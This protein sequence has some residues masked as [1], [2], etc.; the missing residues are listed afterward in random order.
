MT[1]KQFRPRRRAGS[2]IACCVGLI[3]AQSA[4]GQQTAFDIP[5][6][7]AVRAIPEFARQAGL[8]IVAPADE[9]RGVR[10]AALKGDLDARVALRRLL[11][12]T[13]L[14][15]ASDEG[16]LI[17]LRRTGSFKT[18]ALDAAQAQGSAASTEELQE[19]TVRAV[20][21][22][23][24]EVMSANKMPLSVRDTPQTVKIVTQDLLDFAGVHKFED[25]YKID[26]S[27]GTSHAGDALPR[28]YFRGY[29]VQGVNTI[30]VDGF[31]MPAYVELDLA[32]FERF[33]IVKGATST[34]YG[35]NSVAGSLN[36]ISKMP[37]STF[38]G[39]VSLETGSYQHYRADVDLYGPMNASGTLTYRL[40]GAYLDE[41]E[42]VDFS[43][44]KRKV[45][46]PTIRYELSEDTSIV[47]RFNYQ[48]YDFTPY[49]GVGAQFLGTD[50]E[51]P[52]QL[53]PE[54][55]RIPPIP[56]SETGNSPF[57]EASKKAIIAQTTVDHRFGEGGWMLRGNVQYAHMPGNLQGSLDLGTDADGFTDAEL[58]AWDTDNDVYGA[59]VNLFGDVEWGGRKHTLFFGVDYAKLK[60]DGEYYYTDVFGADDG[61]SI[62]N[63]DYSLRQFPTQRTDYAELF[64]NADRREMSGITM[65]ALLRPLDGLIVSLGARYSHDVLRSR[66]A[67]CEIDATLEGAEADRLAENKITKQLGLTYAL[68][69]SMNLYATYGETFE[70][71]TGLTGP[72]EH[73][74]PE[75]GQA[76]EI[77]AKGD[78]LD[79][80]VSYSLALFNLERN[81]I[82]QD[83][84]GSIYLALAGTQRSRGVELDFQGQVV[85]GWEIYV[86]LAAMDAEF[87]KG[88]L[89]GARPANAPKFGASLFTSYEIQDGPCKGLGFG[90]GVVYKAGR[91]MNDLFSYGGVTRTNFLGDYTE[92][93]LRTFYTRNRWQFE[94]AGT[95]LFNEKYYSNAFAQLQTGYQSNPPRQFMG[96][97]RYKF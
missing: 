46:A 32:P 44:N 41:N 80:R 97:V 86:S 50:I 83:I 96:S 13:G 52:A 2:Q 79:K 28:N 29:Q 26:A 40:I 94:I 62:L 73:A 69:P 7:E 74:A 48:K 15:V 11:L 54:N 39:E 57:N 51:D 14:E 30:K 66:T 45:F 81:N 31:R 9:L 78:V 18:S 56:R 95:N 24:D 21:F 33:E 87:T 93:D 89:K 37:K 3:L 10:T 43:S 70:P 17:T 35:Q 90:T 6:T 76:Y 92:V 42:Y 63:P 64:L 16:G 1:T 49:Y 58:Y 12:G 25:F 77:G 4:W 47:A 36:A 27:S 67:C 53:T 75:E 88:T 85:Q 61:F 91:E 20:S 38:G 60:E 59:E 23:Y 68:T 8:Q 19:V 34:L 5:E 55:F 65:Q 22:R 84:P 72:N 71:Q 82:A